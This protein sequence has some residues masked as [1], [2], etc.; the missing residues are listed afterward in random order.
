MKE[1]QEEDEDVEEDV[2]EVTETPKDVSPAATPRTSKDDS[3]A[4]TPRTTV[5]EEDTLSSVSERLSEVSQP[6]NGTNVK[7]EPEEEE[8]KKEND[9]EEE[10]EDGKD[11]STVDDGEEDKEEDN[12]ILEAMYAP[13]V[14]RPDPHQFELFASTEEAARELLTAMN[15]ALVEAQK[16]LS[17]LPKRKGRVSKVRTELETRVGELRNFVE[18]LALVTAAWIHVT[19]RDVTAGERAV[20][21]RVGREVG[22]CPKLSGIKRESVLIPVSALFSLTVLANQLI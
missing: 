4:T 14:T 20:K 7:Q 9:E 6:L 17:A 18:E 11:P 13:E 16:K 3:V 8:I 5:K 1:E 2:S 19:P 10:A 12:R 22:L 15:S 21:V